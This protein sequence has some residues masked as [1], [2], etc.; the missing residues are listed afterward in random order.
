MAQITSLELNHVVLTFCAFNSFISSPCLTK[1]YLA[2]IIV[3]EYEY[4]DVEHGT[5]FSA[6][7]CSLPQLKSALRCP[8]RELHLNMYKSSDLMIM[9]LIATSRYPII[10]KDSLV[11]VE[12]SSHYSTDNHVHLFQWFLDCKAIKS[13]K[14]VHLGDPKLLHFTEQDTTNYD[15]RRFNMFKTVGL[16]ISIG[17]GW[18]PSKPE[19]QWWANS[20]SVIPAGSPLNKLRLIIDFVALNVQALPDVTM[21]MWDDL[22]CALCGDNLDLEHL[23]IDFTS[24]V[25]WHRQKELAMKHQSR[26]ELRVKHTITKESTIFMPLASVNS[27]LGTT[28]PQSASG[29]DTLAIHTGWHTCASQ[30]VEDTASPYWDSDNTLHTGHSRGH[31]LTYLLAHSWCFHLD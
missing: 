24:W 16:C 29:G 30:V 12:L 21:A 23:A 7:D 19:F 3:L 28:I 25:T 14:T 26:E 1:L 31:P 22:D 5:D 20:L 2:G 4:A 6:P 17:R 8:L 9:D 13:V 27:R 11:K 15:L 10:A 18:F